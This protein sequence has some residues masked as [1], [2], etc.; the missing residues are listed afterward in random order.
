MSDNKTIVLT[1]REEIENLVGRT[2]TDEEWDKMYEWITTDDNM[3]SVI[4]ECLR[5]TIDEVLS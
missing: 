4:D 1:D 2:L 5:T 3:W